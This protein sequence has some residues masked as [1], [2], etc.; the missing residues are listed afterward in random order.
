MNGR[1]RHVPRVAVAAVVTVGVRRRPDM[2]AAAIPWK[3]AGPAYTWRQWCS[4]SAARRAAAA[5]AARCWVSRRRATASV[6]AT[7]RARSS[8]S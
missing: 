1:C 5:C 4:C 2:S 3:A 8:S 7:I 6:K